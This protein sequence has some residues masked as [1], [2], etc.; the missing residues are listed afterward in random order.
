MCAVVD[1]LGADG[2]GARRRRRRLECHVHDEPAMSRDPVEHWMAVSLDEFRARYLGRAAHARPGTTHD[3]LGILD[4]HALGR[5]LA[6]HPDVLVVAGGQ[7][8]TLP[9]PRSLAALVEYLR[10]GI[11][12]CVRGA[13]RQDARLAELA[14]AFAPLGAARI[15][16]FVTP[17]HTHGF[18]WHFDDEDVFIAQTAGC[19]HYYFRPNTVAAAEPA[20]PEVFARFAEESSPLGAATLVAGD[21]LYLP[22]RWW[23]M[24]VCEQ[25]SLSISVGVQRRAGG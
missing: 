3:A 20:R 16:L 2:A 10:A 8:L 1:G 15:Q 25:T 23:H 19:K 4:W 9:P 18:G 13:E 14:A 21:A 24:A 5:V 22:S 12:L 6:E 11:G 7:L 17:A